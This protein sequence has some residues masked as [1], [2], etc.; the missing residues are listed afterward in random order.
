M[1]LPQIVTAGIF[2]SRVARKN[3]V[4]S[5]NRK[6]TMFE[7][8]LPIEEGGVSYIDS[9]SLPIAPGTVISIKPNRLRHTKFPYKCYYVHMVVPK[10]ALYDALMN[11]PDFFTTEEFDRYEKIFQKLI[12]SYNSLSPREEIL[13]QSLVLELIY[14][15]S[16][17]SVTD[18]AGKNTA[19]N[20]GVINA[21]L[22]YIK[23]HLTEPLTLERVAGAMSLSPVYFHNTFKFAVGMTLRDYVEEQRLKKAI[24]LLLSTDDSL[25]KIAYECGFSSQS[26]FSSVFKR[27]MK[28]TPRSYVQELYTRY[29]L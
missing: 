9:G 19:G 29:Q 13:L 15:V 25:T 18:C 14:T 26:Y 1:D 20:T 6:T 28:T 23:E 3:A 10:G 11:T 21:S 5:K 12:R 2:D 27:K 8:E 4:I 17:E 7:I 16:K 24:A 22:E